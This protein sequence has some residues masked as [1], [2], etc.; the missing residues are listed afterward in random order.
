MR[1]LILALQA[2]ILNEEDPLIKINNLSSIYAYFFK[3]Y[4]LKHNLLVDISDLYIDPNNLENYDYCFILINRGTTY[5]SNYDGLKNKIKHQIFTICENNKHIGKEDYLIHFVGKEKPKCIKTHFMADHNFLIPK[6]NK[7]K[8]IILVDHKYY[9]DKESRISKTDKTEF[10]IDDLLKY[11]AKNDNK[12]K[13]KEIIIKNIIENQIIVVDN[14]DQIKNTSFKQ[15]AISY[16][17]IC[18]YYNECDIFIN[19]HME[20]MGLSNLEC[21]MSGALILTFKDFLK[22]EFKKKLYTITID[23]NNINWNE[24]FSKIDPVGS[25]DKVINYN[26]ENCVDFI[27]NNYL[28]KN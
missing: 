20:S 8:L 14:I 21:A 10:I 19:T 28:K 3:K 5:I 23:P 27:Y 25:R 16:S 11:K 26:Y 18:E 4:L 24:I 15:S 9:G 6:K 13:N 2:N 7:E 12:Y 17:S 1:I 22:K